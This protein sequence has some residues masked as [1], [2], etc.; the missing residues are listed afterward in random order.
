M[1]T[2]SLRVV[3]VDDEPKVLQGLE[4]MLRPLRAEWTMS[5]ATGGREA[6]DLLEQS[7]VDVLVTDMR[8]PGMNGAESSLDE[9]KR[10]HPHVVR[11]VLS[12]Q[13]DQASVPAP[14]SAR[15]TSTCPSPAT[16]RP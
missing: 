12:G 8:M 11:I 7:R 9:V 4:R 14:P 6:L 15:R 2:P 3:F 1:T 16:P 13:A 5:F 10:R